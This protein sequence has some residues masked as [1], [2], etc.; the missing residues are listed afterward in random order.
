MI[1]N[2]PTSAAIILGD[3][4]IRFALVLIL[5]AATGEA[6]EQIVTEYMEA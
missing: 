6:D 4:M 1:R 5:I 3:D 2:W